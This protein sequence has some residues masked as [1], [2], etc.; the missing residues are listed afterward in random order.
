MIH[1]I[2]VQA[3]IFDFGGVLCFHPAEDRFAAIADLLGVPTARLL[4][5]FW[6][7]RVPYDT[8]LIDSLEYWTRI[9]NGAGKRLDDRLLPTLVERE[10]RLW[11]HFDRRVFQWAGQLKSSGI[12]TAV[13]SNLPRA[14]GEA[15]RATPG[16]LEPFDHLTL[17]YELHLVKPDAEIYRRALRG[18][19]VEPGETLFL[20]DRPPNVEGALAAGIHAEL[21]T[22]WETFLET[23]AGRYKLPILLQ[24][25]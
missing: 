22:T 14:L 5:L 19:G 25:P 23:S 4:D 7:N 13:L 10:I 9:A 24:S 21:F 20:D 16:L 11:N 17:S 18:L 2:P 15:L 8:G 6:A 12:R 1:P 3:V